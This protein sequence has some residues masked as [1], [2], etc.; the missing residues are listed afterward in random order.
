VRKRGA[1]AFKVQRARTLRAT[2]Y[3]PSGPA[4]TDAEARAGSG[5][6]IRT[7]ERLRERACEIGPIGALVRK[8]RETPAVPAK[9][10]GEVEPA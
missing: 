5:L 2:D 4:L 6:N 9:V 8:R 10:T 7:I 1:A 3:G